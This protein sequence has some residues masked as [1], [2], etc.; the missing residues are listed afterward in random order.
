M[1]KKFWIVQFSFLFNV[2]CEAITKIKKVREKQHRKII[3]IMRL[4]R[5]ESSTCC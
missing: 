3:S 1:V 2:L 5:F 4:A